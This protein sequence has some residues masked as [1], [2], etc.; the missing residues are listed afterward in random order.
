MPFP[1]EAFT[2]P[3]CP[4]HFSSFS[5]TC[6]VRMRTLLSSWLNL[7]DAKTAFSQQQEDDDDVDEV[8]GAHEAQ[9]VGG[10]VSNAW[11]DG[12][13]QQRR[14]EQQPEDRI[15]DLDFFPAARAA[16]YTPAV[17]KLPRIRQMR[18]SV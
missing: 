6:S 12:Q 14:T 15:L 1:W 2:G 8:D 7:M 13:N 16:G 3:A 18:M 11:E 9:Q 4:L 17:M 5:A 10:P